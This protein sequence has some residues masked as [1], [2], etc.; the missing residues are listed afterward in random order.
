MTV[1]VECAASELRQVHGS[2]RN[3]WIQR[4]AGA[5]LMLPRRAPG[6]KGRDAKEQ[7]R[8]ECEGASPEQRR[9]QNLPGELFVAARR[10]DC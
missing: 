2:R 6:K 8:G 4:L 10:R 3:V 7:Q 9:T 1:P 5:A